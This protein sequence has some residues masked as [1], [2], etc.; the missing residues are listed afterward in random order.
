MF[1]GVVALGY[2]L[3]AMLI[4]ECHNSHKYSQKPLTNLYLEVINP[5][6]K[7]TKCQKCTHT[8]VCKK[9][10]E[11]YFWVS[12]VYAYTVIYNNRHMSTL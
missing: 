3:Y 10:N 8:A 5:L 2:Q 1:I 6:D 12:L 11:R 4:T 7:D 9:E